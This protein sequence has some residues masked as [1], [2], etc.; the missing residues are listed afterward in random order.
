MIGALSHHA[1][2]RDGYW[3]G[4]ND[5]NGRPLPFGAFEHELFPEDQMK[6]LIEYIDTPAILEIADIYGAHLE[7][8][9]NTQKFEL[10]GYLG[11]WVAEVLAA[12]DENMEV[13]WNHRS[14][15]DDPDIHVGAILDLCDSMAVDEVCVFIN[16]ITEM[17]TL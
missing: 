3:Y 1:L 8:L 2:M 13:P 4:L 7:R 6:K 15:E 10:I 5:E 12:A 14:V 11:I 17:V 16:A 9:S